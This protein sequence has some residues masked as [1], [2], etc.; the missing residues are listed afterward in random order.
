MRLHLGR[1]WLRLLIWRGVGLLLLLITSKI[2]FWVLMLWLRTPQWLMNLSV[3]SNFLSILKMGT[4]GGGDSR[5]A[6][7]LAVVSMI[8]TLNLMPGKTLP[9]SIRYLLCS[10]SYIVFPTFC[11]IIRIWLEY[12]DK[13][14]GFYTHPIMS[15]HIWLKIV[16]F[17]NNF[18]KSVG[19]QFKF[20]ISNLFRFKKYYPIFRIIFRFKDI[21][22]IWGICFF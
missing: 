18:L 9:C 11:F 15:W 3:L 6:K 19:N 20:L 2:S 7:L 4:F 5:T 17:D 14:K 22:F 13:C 16:Y 1:M 21:V 12:K 8:W 10:L